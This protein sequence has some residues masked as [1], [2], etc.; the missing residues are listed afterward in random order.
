MALIVLRNN[1]GGKILLKYPCTSGEIGRML[2]KSSLETV[3]VLLS[4][5][6]VVRN[7]SYLV[8]INLPGNILVFF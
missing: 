8:C 5:T 6:P 4:A 1:V 2:Q 7:S 3:L